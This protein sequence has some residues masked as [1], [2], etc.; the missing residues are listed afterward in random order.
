MKARILHNPRCSKSREALAILK[1]AGADVEVVEYLKDAPS[2]GELR[3]LYEKAGMSPRD[4]LRTA[5]PGAK[6][7]RDADDATLLEAMASDPILIERPLVETEKGVRLGR[8][9]ERVREIL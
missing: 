5:E 3:R 8:P 6:L 4:G 1:D 9:P 7:L 2:A